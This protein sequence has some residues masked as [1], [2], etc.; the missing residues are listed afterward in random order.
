MGWIGKLFAK[1]GELS[2]RNPWTSIFIGLILI[3]FGTLG[4]VNFQSTVS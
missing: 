1:Q 2:A 4:F 3:T